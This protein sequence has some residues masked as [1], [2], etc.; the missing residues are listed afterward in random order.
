[1]L[2][3]KDIL[4]QMDLPES[5]VKV[6]VAKELKKGG[7]TVYPQTKE[8]RYVNLPV[9]GECWAIIFED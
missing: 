3:E 9:I 4:E 1:M 6:V 7:Y 8:L 2:T 5:D